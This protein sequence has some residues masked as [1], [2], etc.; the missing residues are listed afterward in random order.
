MESCIPGKGV[1]KEVMKIISSY[2]TYLCVGVTK[3]WKVSGISFVNVVK[4]AFQFTQFSI[5]IEDRRSKCSLQV[6]D[7]S[8]NLLSYA[9]HRQS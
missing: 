8:S 4:V 6:A 1:T 5:L 7:L 9:A 2:R 3:A